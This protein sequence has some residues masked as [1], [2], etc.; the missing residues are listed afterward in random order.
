[1]TLKLMQLAAAAKH[2]EC[3]VLEGWGFMD[4]AYDDRRIVMPNAI[5]NQ[6]CRNNV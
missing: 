6:V 3:L 1:M 4:P 2:V 5:G